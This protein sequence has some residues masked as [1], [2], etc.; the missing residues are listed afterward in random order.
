[1]IRF[2]IK[3]GVK[4]AD[5]TQKSIAKRMFV[6]PA[7]LNKILLGKTTCNKAT[8]FYITYLHLQ[9]KGEL[10]SD[11]KVYTYFEEVK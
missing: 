6:E 7:T 11:S 8:A 5:S 9:A 3:D 10:I 1:M 4:V 2:R